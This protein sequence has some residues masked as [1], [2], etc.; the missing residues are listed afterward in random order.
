MHWRL[1]AGRV[2]DACFTPVELHASPLPERPIYR[3]IKLPDA[4]RRRHD[5]DVVEVCED[6]LTI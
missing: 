6:G 2:P 5:I 3:I 1:F 4:L